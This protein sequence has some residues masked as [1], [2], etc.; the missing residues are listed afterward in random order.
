EEPLRLATRKGLLLDG[1]EGAGNFDLVISLPMLRDLSFDDVELAFGATF[2]GVRLPGV[3]AGRDLDSSDF[4]V[5]AGPTWFEARG[6]GTIVGVPL[7][8]AFVSDAANDSEILTATGRVNAD[9]LDDLGVPSVLGLAG[10]VAIDASADVRDKDRPN[11]D[12]VVDITTAEVLFEPLSLWKPEGIQGELRATVIQEPAGVT[13]ESATASWAGVELAAEG[14]V[15]AAG[16]L[17][18]LLVDPIVIGGSSARL[19][20][21][22]EGELL[23]VQLTGSRLEFDPQQLFR[24]QDRDTR[25]AAPA[26]ATA[27]EDLRATI[28]LG[29][30]VT[31]NGLGF[32]QVTGLVER[33]DGIIQRADLRGATLASAAPFTLT[34]EPR[35]A[36]HQL[37]LTSDDAGDVLQGLGLSQAL[38][39]GRLRID[40]LITR[41][42]PDLLAEGSLELDDFVI[43]KGPT[44]IKVL[45]LTPPI[46]GLDP[47]AIQIDRFTGTFGIDGDTLR[48]GDVLMVGSNIAVRANGTFDLASDRIDLQGNLAPLATVNR[49]LGRVPLIGAL[50]QGSSGAGAFAVTFT[51][52]GDPANPEVT[53]N[54]FSLLAPGVLRDLFGGTPM[55]ETN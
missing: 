14:S 50:L 43:R 23:D 44:A 11:L 32:A 52:V 38:H 37:V 45:S 9:D 28:D 39:G 53:V 33:V 31:G 42:R 1:V 46:E 18:R 40:G 20:I 26:D 48:I 34:I 51:V 22:R 15:D 41:Q 17:E 3:I 7:N 35:T 55:P 10:T 5:R 21:V 27:T 30:V 49:F 8:L 16:R 12:V 13:I 47:D 4:E 25:P 54:P 6:R 19:A 24:Q 36:G 2:D 29:E